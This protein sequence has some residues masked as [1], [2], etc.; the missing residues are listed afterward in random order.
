MMSVWEYHERLVI[1]GSN[2]DIGAGAIVIGN[3]QIGADAVI[4]KDISLITWW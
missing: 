2:V 4:T 3:V 1:I